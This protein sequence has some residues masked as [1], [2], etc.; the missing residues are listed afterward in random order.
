MN[1]QDNNIPL[2][3]NKWSKI[4]IISNLIIL[5]SEKKKKIIDKDNEICLLYKEA[6]DK[7][8]NDFIQS[9]NTNMNIISTFNNY[10]N[11]NNQ[12]QKVNKNEQIEVQN[13]NKNVVTNLNLIYDK[14]IFLKNSIENIKARILRIQ[15]KYCILEKLIEN[16][17]DNIEDLLVV[18][19]R[20]ISKAEYVQKMNKKNF[21]IVINTF[22][23]V[24]EKFIINFRENNN[25]DF[26]QNT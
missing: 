14:S 11:D 15:K 7:H 13:K 5:Y 16:T 2:K 24:L 22:I 10:I 12:N 17:E 6:Q 26:H 20:T 23:K 8:I 19:N 1:S 25:I 18:F 3:F 9:D 4:R 21:I